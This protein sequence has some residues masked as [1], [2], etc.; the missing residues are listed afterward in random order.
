MSN[1]KR[2]HYLPEFY[3]KGFSGEGG[4]WLYDRKENL[5]RNASPKN[6]GLIGHYYSINGSDG[7]KNPEVERILSVIEGH[8]SSAI[9][10]LE[11]YGDLSDDGRYYLALFCALFLFRTPDFEADYNTMMSG[12]MKRM[13]KESFCDAS[14]AEQAIAAFNSE[15]GVEKITS[16][17]EDFVDFVVRD[18][19]TINV[20]RNASL[21]VILPLSEKIAFLLHHMEWIAVHNSTLLPFFTCD[22]PFVIV[23]PRDWNPNSWQGVGILT[24]GA[25]FIVPLTRK[26]SLVMGGEKKG[27]GH[28]EVSLETHINP[29]NIAIASMTERFLLG[30]HEERLRELVTMSKID[31]IERGRRITL[32]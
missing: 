5:F 16:K 8:A 4:I 13:L 21:S 15:S 1:P 29:Q 24:P 7:E 23:P 19:F 17:P 26:L 18:D 3:Q 2:H 25:H 14:H 27:L 28:R 12:M 22:A 10:T 20:M 11:R 6:T 9:D 31:V 32:L 30:P